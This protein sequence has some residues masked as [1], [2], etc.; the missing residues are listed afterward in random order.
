MHIVNT[1]SK[2][3]SDWWEKQALQSGSSIAEIATIDETKASV[4]TG[5]LKL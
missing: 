3:T 4:K 5:H 1:I 2:R